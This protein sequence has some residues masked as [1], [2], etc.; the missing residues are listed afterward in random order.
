MG[1]ARHT[2][3]HGQA[4]DAAAGGSLDGRYRR[5]Y[6]TVAAIPPGKVASYGQVADQ[7]GLPRRARLVG[8][9][10]AQCPEHLPWHRVLGAGGRIALPPGSAACAEQLRRLKAEGVE[11]SSGRVKLAQHGWCPGTLD[12]LLWGPPRA[13]NP[14]RPGRARRSP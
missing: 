7:A 8:R 9:A 12:E 6:E 13:D 11:I 2:R 1:S 4:A 3:I 10:L 14:A 5:I